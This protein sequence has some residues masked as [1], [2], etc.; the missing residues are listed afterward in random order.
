MASYVTRNV[1]STMWSKTTEF[2]VTK[3]NIF[4]FKPKVPVMEFYNYTLAI[5][6]P[7]ALY[8]ISIL[9]QNIFNLQKRIKHIFLALLQQLELNMKFPIHTELNFTEHYVLALMR[10]TLSASFPRDLSISLL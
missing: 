3:L 1:V 8:K 10:M 4:L 2:T 7:C 9:L 5:L 6:T